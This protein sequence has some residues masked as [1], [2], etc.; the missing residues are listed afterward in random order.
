MR[1][2][3]EIREIGPQPEDKMLFE[4]LEK[5]YIPLMYPKDIMEILPASVP[6]AGQ[7]GSSSNIHVVRAWMNYPPGWVEDWMISNADLA[8]VHAYLDFLRR[9]RNRFNEVAEKMGYWNSDAS[10]SLG[11]DRWSVGW[12]GSNLLSIA[13]YLYSLKSYNVSGSL[14]ECGV[15]KGSSTACLSWACRELGLTLYSADSFAGLPSEEGHYNAADF[16][17]S[18][19]EVTRNVNQYGY[20]ECVQF[21]PGWYSES[22]KNFAPTIALLWVDVDLQQSTLDVLN[23][24]FPRLAKDAVIFS[25][26]FTEGVD[27]DGYKVR[28]TGG[29]PAGFARF[30]EATGIGYKAMPGGAKGLA[31]ILPNCQEDEQPLFNASAFQYLLSL[32]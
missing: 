6:R 5:T 24:V 3:L 29:E 2:T 21:I 26:G 32:L 22:L 12:A 9:A 14:L 8:P 31:L 18:L 4:K 10:H 13:A 16:R 27:F 28:H 7:E 17:G 15:F 19:D 20:P 23:N 30:F 1:K 25:D 11:H